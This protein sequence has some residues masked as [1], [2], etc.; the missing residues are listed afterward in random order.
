MPHS[1][2][3]GESLFQQGARQEL[4][5][6]NSP[7]SITSTLR[8]NVWPHAHNKSI[9]LPSKHILSAWCCQG[10]SP[11]LLLIQLKLATFDTIWSSLA[12]KDAQVELYEQWKNIQGQRVQRCQG[13]HSLGLPMLLLDVWLWF[14]HSVCGRKSSEA[15]DTYQATAQQLDKYFV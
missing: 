3:T 7:L 10:H 8:V 13:L 11:E 9:N 1:A 14:F 6:E 12:P 2:K 15:W 4:T 5:P